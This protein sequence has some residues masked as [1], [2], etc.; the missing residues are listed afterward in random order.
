MRRRLP[1][2]LAAMACLAACDAPFDTGS[3][4]WPRVYVAERVGVVQLPAP[5]TLDEGYARRVHA[6]TI[7]LAADGT[8]RW[9][10]Y[11]DLRAPW[12]SAW[13]PMNSVSAARWRVDGATLTLSWP[14]CVACLSIAGPSTF[15]IV[16]D[17]LV[18]EQGEYGV[19]R[20]RFRP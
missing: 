6:D 2:L 20:W 7:T 16:F 17:D 14:P 19:Q 3:G 5:L 4:K 15:T 12:D 8:A 9:A 13:V 10:V 1:A 11:A 18:Q